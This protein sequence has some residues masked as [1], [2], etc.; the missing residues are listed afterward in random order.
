MSPQLPLTDRNLGFLDQRLAL[1]W[2][3]QNIHAFGGDPEKITI[4]GQSAGSASVDELVTTTPHNPPFRAAIMQSGQTSIYVNHN[5][6]N[7]PQ[8]D[9]LIEALNCTSAKDVLKCAR[10]ANASTIKTTEQND[11]LFFA[12]IS[13]N[14]TQLEFPEAARVAKNV[15]QVPILTGS[16]ANEGRVFAMGQNNTTEYLKQ[17][18]PGQPNFWSAIESAY[19]LGSSPNL[20]NSYYVNSAIFT[21]YQ[22]QCPS[23][24][25][26]NDSYASGI[27]AWRYWYNATFPNLDFSWDGGKLDLGVFHGSE[28]TLVFGTFP[29]NGATKEQ[30]ELS[31]NMQK[32]WADFAKNPIKGP[33]WKGYPSVNV[34]GSGAKERAVDASALDTHCDLYREVYEATGVIG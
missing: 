21:D 7:T 30:M 28:I 9:A 29:R 13:D 20:A 26:A 32:A 33:G 17:L 5:N 15:A 6:S 12:P 22:F 34:F 16:V 23:A 31:Q 27:P 2:T 1:E 19:P 3:R 24:I 25:A 10:S 8:W 11:Y 14:K 18:F 4:F